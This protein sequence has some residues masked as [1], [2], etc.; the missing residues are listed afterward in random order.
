MLL[1]VWGCKKKVSSNLQSETKEAKEL[2]IY[3][4]NSM[5]APLLELKEAFE[6]NH[7]CV[8]RIQNDCS[9]NLIGLL[10]YSRRGDLFIPGSGSAFTSL[11][12]KTDFH[13]TDTVFLGYNQLVFMVKKGNPLNFDGH[14]NTLLKSGY[15]IIIANPATSSLG[16]ETKKVLT[17][18][19]VY[20][21]ILKNVVALTSDSK[22]LVKSLQNDQ[23][24]VV[25][26]WEN[27]YFINGNK[28][29]ID[30]IRPLSAFNEAI[31]VYAASLS[32]S[33]EPTLAREFL[34]LATSESGENALRKY[35][36]SKR[37][38]IIF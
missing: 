16:H 7:D 33:E 22:G 31:P 3:C 29:H 6:K 5:V 8:V 10:N 15:P 4:E 14:L 25:I 28:D 13:L 30:I 36:F 32:C 26:N 21:K 18:N 35:G 11:T 2:L 9:Q 34:N 24:D 12:S 20:D 19:H 38:P 27:S 37:K 1:S 23:A 17:K